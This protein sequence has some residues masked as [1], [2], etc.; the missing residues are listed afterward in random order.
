MISLTALTILIYIAIAAAVAV[1]IVLT[2]F[3]LRDW[4]RGD[5]W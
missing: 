3:L 2:I 1:P 5:L 4:K